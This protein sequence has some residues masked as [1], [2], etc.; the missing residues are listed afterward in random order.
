MRTAEQVKAEFF[1]TPRDSVRSLIEA[2]VL[3][4]EG[5]WL[6]PFAGAGAIIRAVD[7]YEVQEWWALEWRQSETE[8]LIKLLG[9]DSGHRVACPWD[10]F[11][12]DAREWIQSVAPRVVISNPPNS[13]AF[14]AAVLLREWV[15]EAWLALYQPLTFGSGMTK[16]RLE[17]LLRN[18]PDVL[19]TQDR[20]D[21]VGTGG[22]QEYAWF[23]WPPSGA[24]PN[25]DFGWFCEFDGNDYGPP[26][27]TSGE[28]RVLPPPGWAPSTQEVLL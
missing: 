14:D 21:F 1:S 2:N 19:K 22:I 10:F 17:W 24:G 18:T 9:D 23:V 7:V 4:L 28:F 5:R 11:S 6:E 8:G 3:P 20:P 13:R 27:R 12:D 16:G 15:P 26:R 25:L